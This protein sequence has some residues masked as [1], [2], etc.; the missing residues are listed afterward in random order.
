MLTR[1]RRALREQSG[2]SAMVTAVVLVML[3]GV[4]AL[5][6]DVGQI[7]AV[8]GEIKRAV[9]AGA[10]AGARGLWPLGNELPNTGIP[11]PALY[12]ACVTAATNATNTATHTANKVAGDSLGGV[13]AEVG[14][15]DFKAKTF[16]QGCSG[17]ANAV[18][19]T[20]TKTA[21]P[22]FFAKVFGTT[23][24]DRTASAVAVMDWISGVGKGC[25][26]IAINKDYTTPYAV[27]KQLLFIN[28][29]PDTVDDGGWFTDPPDPA[30]AKTL[31]NYINND[32]VPPLEIGEIINLNN[33]N[34]T[35]V[36][37]L[38]ADKLAAHGGTWDVVLPVVTT[39][40]FNQ[41]WPIFSFVG[42]EITDVVA[43]GSSK[44]VWGKVLGLT[45]TTNGDPGGQGIGNPNNGVL[46]TPKLVQVP[47][48]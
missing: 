26:P 23:S 9:E 37:Q 41:S 19:V 43:T 33:G 13:T 25:L 21:V 14:R 22:T 12:P 2:A 18:R 38:L 40:K 28:F 42:F 11:D 35:S 10:L 39:G 24:F 7:Y 3:V 5:A 34:D 17:N 45:F 47:G 46:S 20:A 8:Q 15:W 29:T 16:T 4:A 31:K 30:S 32:S 1:L 6:V 27:T 36:L 44:G 48:A